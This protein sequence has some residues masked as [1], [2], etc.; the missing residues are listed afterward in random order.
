MEDKMDSNTTQFYT[1]L[2]A[3]IKQRLES[4]AFKERHR[5]SKQAFTRE[6]TLTFPIITLFFLNQVKHALQ[7]ELDEFFKVLEGGKV[8]RRVV[9]K[10]GLSQARRKLVHTA[11]IELNRGQVAYF[12]EQGEPQKWRGLR[13]LAIDGSMGDLPN[14]VGISEHFGVWH[15][16]SGGTC[17]KARLSQ[18][19][20]VLN[21]ITVDA[22]IGPKSDG[23]RVLAERHLA[24]VGVDDLLIMDRGYPAFWLFAAILA[25]KAHFCARLSVSEWAVAKKFVAS[26]K[27]EQLFRLRPGYEAG[28]ACLARGLPVEPI[29]VRLIRVE[30]SSGEV[31][32]LATTLLDTTRFPQSVFQEL[33]HQRWP[34]EED[35]EV[36][37]SRLQVENWSGKTIEAVYQEFHAAVC[38]KN[39]AAILAQPAQQVVAQQS[40]GKKYSYQVNMTNLLSKLKDTIAYLLQ[41]NDLLAY[42]QALWQQMV[43][44]VEPIRPGRSFPRP[45]K[46][47]RKRFAMSYKPTR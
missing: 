43:K 32:V 40:Q 8:A 15:P 41:D 14:G 12:Y 47:K 36:M 38:T 5:V 13:L 33:Y 42:L 18:M 20:D 25:K 22:L 39:T 29:R 7:D 2:I 35:Y 44:T 26:G 1:G 30:L 6:R 16:Q 34:V 3:C 46:V 37:K 23:E 17:A 45:K 31:E 11:Y 24:H 19:F 21:H 9:T 10:S 28:K 4:E 27:K